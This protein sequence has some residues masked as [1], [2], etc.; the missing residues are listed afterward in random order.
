MSK[1]LSNAEKTDIG[2]VVHELLGRLGRDVVK[3]KLECMHSSVWKV[4]I[5]SGDAHLGCFVYAR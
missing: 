4:A 5:D 1:D 3:E 2:A